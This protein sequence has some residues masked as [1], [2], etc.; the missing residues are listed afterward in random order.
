MTLKKAMRLKIPPRERKAAVIRTLMDLLR[1][2]RV[3]AIADITGLRANQFQRLRAKL[4]G[5]AEVKVAKNTLMR[6]AI[7]FLRG[8]RPGLE[9]LI[10]HLTGPNAFIFT[11][12]NVFSLY[13]FLERNKVTAKARPGDRASKDVVIPAGNT[14][15]P[16]GPILSVFKMLKVPTRIEEGSIYVAKDTVILRQGE[17]ISREAADLLA[18]LG[19]EPIE[20]GLRVKVAYEDGVI[21]TRDDLSLDLERYKKE[22]AEAYAN[23]LCLSVSV[24]YPTPE[25]LNLIIGRAH[26]EAL[27]LAVNAAIPVKGAAELL[28]QRAVAQAK[29]TCRAG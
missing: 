29:P 27:N 22:V 14:G 4:R 19:I 18:K 7:E 20:V 13:M 8:E 24:A 11:N 28:I 1:R 21:L 25:G 9:K 26:L 10:D 12:E 17:V 16:P 5:M 6:K 15:I 2:Y 3:V 23:A